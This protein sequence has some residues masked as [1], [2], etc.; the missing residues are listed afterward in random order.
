MRNALLIL[1]AFLIAAA[2]AGALAQVGFLP[3]ILAAGGAAVTAA[4]L[5]AGVLTRKGD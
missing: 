1:F 2:A 4:C 5:L 3:V